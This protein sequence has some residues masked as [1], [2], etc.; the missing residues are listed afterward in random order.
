MNELFLTGMT[1]KEAK[2]V[3]LQKG[4]TDY[5]VTV[6]CPPRCK[7]LNADD[8]FRVLLVYPNHYPMTILVCKP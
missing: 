6:T 4:I 5:R 8:D 7:N 2:T 1:L 3:L